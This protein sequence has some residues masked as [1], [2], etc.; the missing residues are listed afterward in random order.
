[1]KPVSVCGVPTERGR[2]CPIPVDVPG[3]PCH[4]HDPEG[5]FARQHPRYRDRLVA[6][7]A[8]PDPDAQLRAWPGL[9]C[10]LCRRPVPLGDQVLPL[11]PHPCR[12]HLT[13]G[14]VTCVLDVLQLEE[15]GPLSARP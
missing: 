6:R 7:S 9:R 1:M 11:P 5:E 4:V 12:R 2:P 14:H 8:R 10:W 13:Y 3:R 15:V